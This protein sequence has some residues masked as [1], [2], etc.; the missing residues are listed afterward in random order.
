MI[1]FPR[2]LGK[3][4]SL[5]IVPILI[6]CQ[7]K[8]LDN[9]PINVAF[10]PYSSSVILGEISDDPTEVFESFQPLADYLTKQL[11]GE[12]N[13]TA[14][15]EVAPNMETMAK[16]LKS[17]KV[18]LYFDSPYPAFLVSE[19]SD[20]EVI[21]SRWKGR[22]STYNSVIITLCDQGMKEINDLRGK[23]IA[24]EENFSTSG[25]MLPYSYLKQQGLSLIEKTSD[26]QSISE[27]EIRYVFSGNDNNSLQWLVSGRVAA[28]AMG[29]VDFEKLPA[30]TREQFIIIGETRSVPRHMV[31]ISPT[32]SKNK[33]TKL[34]KILLE[35]NAS[36][37]GEKILEQF[38]ET[39]KFA[40]IPKDESD[41]FQ[42]IRPLINANLKNIE[43]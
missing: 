37:S 29:S 15:V 8:S 31:V 17:G 42:E 12:E 43:Y 22:V 21:L 35:M 38:E 16:W 23:T 40:E 41:I 30:E 14:K 20:A 24:F 7:Q 27:N 18:E 36:E 34:K 28:I 13:I 6:S 5:L 25:Y 32:L 19:A 2:Y 10:K 4:I 11:S 39:T 9:P 33:I 1:S 3:A 26:S